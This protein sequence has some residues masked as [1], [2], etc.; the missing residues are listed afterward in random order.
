MKTGHFLIHASINPTPTDSNRWVLLAIILLAL[1]AATRGADDTSPKPKVAF[2]PLA[3]TASE[4]LRAKCGFSLRAKLDR[5]GLYEVIDGPRMAD[6]AALSQTPVGFE[7]SPAAIRELGNAVEATV[8]VWGELSN[9]SRGATMRLNVLDLREK[10]PKPRQV[11]KVIGEPTDL[12]FVSEQILESLPGVQKFE[13]PIE[14][15]VWN[16]ATADKLWKTNPNLVANGDF[17]K[18]GS[19]E[20]IRQSERYPVTISAHLPPEN[21]VCIY[22]MPGENGAAANNVLAMNM[23]KACAE[24]E[25]L[26]CWSALMPIRPGVR[27]RLSCRYKSDSPDLQLFV[28]G[29]TWGED[30]KGQ[31]TLREVYRRQVPPS[32]KTDG[33]WVTIMDDMNPQHVAFPVQFLRV[34]LYIYLHPGLVMFD[35]VALKAVGKQ[36]QQA[37]DDAIKKPVTRP[38][39]AYL[40]D[41]N[42]LVLASQSR[43]APP[44]HR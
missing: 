10:A 16:D 1:C 5:T 19:W 18:P 13:H 31:K 23:S 37:H 4:D 36:T 3:G 9:S 25:G 33:K 14:Q 42:S 6:V 12:R 17:S 11:E 34:D 35:D 38:A 8:L 24:N 41:C 43:Y 21:K 2:F 39:G 27:Y 7:T 30:I 29:Y 20:G 22:T 40:G 32:G 15:S 28:K 44:C 26:A